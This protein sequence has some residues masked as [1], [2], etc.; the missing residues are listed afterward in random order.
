MGFH[1]KAACSGPGSTMQH[2]GH[3]ALQ[4]IFPQQ[5]AL[6]GAT[7][8]NLISQNAG[9]QPN[10]FW[11]AQCIIRET[12]RFSTEVYLQATDLQTWTGL[13]HPSC[14]DRST[15]ESYA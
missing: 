1:L 12:Q 8:T 13:C 3:G 15:E 7:S 11:E 5:A 4:T 6:S 14:L 10:S 9:A 2:L